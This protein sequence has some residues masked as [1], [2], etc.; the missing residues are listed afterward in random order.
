MPPR[1]KT[2]GGEETFIRTDDEVEVLLN[3]TMDYKA[4]KLMEG[5]DWES[6]QSKYGDITER[7]AQYLLLYNNPILM[8]LIKII[9]MIQR[10]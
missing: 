10:I 2:A 4:Q 5:V 8:A 7:V 3:I 1:K 6:V 9:L